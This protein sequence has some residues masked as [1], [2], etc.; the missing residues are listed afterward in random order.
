[1]AR[2]SDVVESIDKVLPRVVIDG[3]LNPSSESLS[4]R[5]KLEIVVCVVD[6]GESTE[7]LWLL[8]NELE[9]QRLYSRFGGPSWDVFCSIF[10]CIRNP[11]DLS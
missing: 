8:V 7:R 9:S 1:M 3:D 10:A 11:S 6:V 4:G 5:R 2:K